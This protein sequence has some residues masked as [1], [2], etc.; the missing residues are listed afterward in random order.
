MTTNEISIKNSTELREW[1]EAN[2]DKVSSAWL[3]YPKGKDRTIE[4]SE[5]VEQLL[6]FGW[7]DSVA[8]KVDENRSKIYISPRKPKSMWSKVNK[9]RVEK[10]IKSGLMTKVG[11]D[12]VNL[13]KKTG[14]WDAL[15]DVDNLVIPNDLKKEFQNYKDAEENFTNFSSSA[16]K[17]MLTWILSAKTE[18]T[19]TKRI[20]AIAENAAK[21]IKAKA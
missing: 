3:V 18:E 2:H 11:M 13:A 7:I 21:N 1:L 5:I 17:V 4:M 20:K 16:K 9:A 8:G 10:L 6:C 12:K 14:T 19:R 15:N